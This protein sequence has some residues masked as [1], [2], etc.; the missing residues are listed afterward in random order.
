MPANGNYL[1]F[2][3]AVSIA[4]LLVLILAVKLHAFLALLLTSMA[5]GLAAHM[6]PEKVLKWSRTRSRS[7]I[8]VLRI[9]SCG[10]SS[11]GSL[12]LPNYVKDPVTG[13][14]RGWTIDLGR[15]LAARIGVESVPVEHQTPP[16]A[17]ACLKAGACD[18]AILGID[19]AR[20]AEVDYSPPILQ[21]D[22]TLLV[23]AGS[24]I[25]SLADIDRAGVRI[26]V[27]RNHAST[28][29]SDPDAETFQSGLR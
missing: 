28:L 27:V 12:L 16:Q 25:Q 13:E 21:L 7:P 29:D 6:P 18:V 9:S 5:L 22:Y 26:A 3:T 23:S 8:D 19:A 15:A 11:G 4:L 20:L 10:Q 24:S 17:I 2:L 1:I 14:L